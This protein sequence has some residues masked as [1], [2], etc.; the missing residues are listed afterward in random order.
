[1]AKNG[2]TTAA[3]QN[4]VK[5]FK[6]ASIVS[7]LKDLGFRVETTAE[8]LRAVEINPKDIADARVFRADT[9]DKLVYEVK[10]ALEE[11]AA[12][13]AIEGELLDSKEVEPEAEAATNGQTGVRTKRAGKKTAEDKGDALFE[14]MR[15]TPQTE[16]RELEILVANY[17]T[18]KL[19]RV[20]ASARETT[21]KKDLDA[22]MHK[23][24]DCLS[25]D[26]N[27]GIKSYTTNDGIIA[28]LVPGKETIQTRHKGE[29][30]E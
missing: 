25:L 14:E 26:P 15:P 30:E 29:G 4:Y 27:T 21:A 23:F 22:G 11:D 19:A 1:M 3:K 16:S 24:V 5:T 13:D 10:S 20:D 2:A 28:E 6:D 9:Y 17:H 12:L 18:A 8:G 7:E